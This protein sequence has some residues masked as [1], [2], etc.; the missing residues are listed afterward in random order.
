[1]VVD[2]GVVAVVLPNPALATA[3]QKVSAKRLKIVKRG[4]YP[5]YFKS[6]TC[7]LHKFS[8]HLQQCMQDSAKLHLTSFVCIALV[9]F[10]CSSAQ[11]DS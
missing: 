9:A 7:G 10:C 4:I 11:D 6:W 5:Q 3:V 2:A 1:M 8:C